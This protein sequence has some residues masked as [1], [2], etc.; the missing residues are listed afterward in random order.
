MTQTY[1]KFLKFLFRIGWLFGST[2]FYS[3]DKGRLV[4]KTIFR[5]LSAVTSLILLGSI[6]LM[7]YCIEMSTQYTEFMKIAAIS[8]LILSVLNNLVVLWNTVWKSDS[9][10][11]LLH[12]LKIADEILLSPQLIPIK[13]KIHRIFQ[14]KYLI[15]LL[16]LWSFL[17]TYNLITFNFTGQ[18]IPMLVE[19]LSISNNLDIA[20]LWEI[21]F[22]IYKNFEEVNVYLKTY[23]L[24]NSFLLK[25]DDN[26]VFTRDIMRVRKKYANIVYGIKE[27]NKI[28]GIMFL[29]FVFKAVFYALF[30]I[31]LLITELKQQG[32]DIHD[33][34]KIA[35]IVLASVVSSRRDYY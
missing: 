12:H 5:I 1:S 18:F 22:L 21:C 29:I 26:T 4:Y 11:K 34:L 31:A 6:V 24:K 32:V 10:E 20:L 15:L 30:Y 33:F 23:S 17:T 19:I 3:F 13:P 27:Y 8:S 28:F 14:K 9:W 2:P 7:L 35:G 25:G 16:A